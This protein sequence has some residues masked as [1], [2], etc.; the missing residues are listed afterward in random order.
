MRFLLAIT[1]F[2][3]TSAFA[4]LTTTSSLS[5]IVTDP[6]GAAVP[7]ARI[8]VINPLNGQRFASVSSARGEWTVP[9]LPTA[10][11]EATISAQGFKTAKSAD[12]KIDPGVPATLNVTLEIGSVSETVEVQ[13]GV[14]ILQT[15]TATVS[16]TLV[17]RQLSE[18]PFT[19]RNLTE[20]LVTQTGTSTP[21]IPRSSSV[22]GLPRG[23]MNV[24]I[25]GVNVQDNSFRISDGFFQAVQPR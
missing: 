14:E 2:F 17:G 22:N 25:D 5:G 13:G 12:I 11:Y 7:G 9:S 3:G 8:T 6:Q 15:A 10:V 16:S 19:S 4:Q 23:A 18:L 21:G 1:L 24:T 20:L